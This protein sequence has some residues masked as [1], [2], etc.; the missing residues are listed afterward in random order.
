MQFRIERSRVKDF[1]L[2]NNMKKKITFFYKR[3]IL[4]GTETLILRMSKWLKQN[5]YEVEV[6]CNEIVEEL[7]RSFENDGIKIIIIKNFTIKEYLSQ[8]SIYNFDI[9]F[10]V[11]FSF[12][13]YFFSEYMKM[14]LKNKKIKNI[15]YVLLP[16][17]TLRGRTTKITIK[18]KVVKHIY[19]KII[20]KMYDSNSIFFMDEVCIESCSK[21]YNLNMDRSYDEIIRLPMFINDIKLKNTRKSP[22]LNILAIAR[23]DFP[24]KGY[25]FGLIDVINELKK[26]NVYLTIIGDG[27]GMEEIRKKIK[28]LG[29]GDVI[30]LA[31]NVPYNDLRDYFDR[32][33]LYVGMGTTLLDASNF[34]VPAISVYTHTYEFLT[35]GF[36]YEYPHLLGGN[37]DNLEYPREKG[38]NIVKKVMGMSS[39]EYLEI[40]RKSYDS[41]KNMYDINKIMPKMLKICFFSDNLLFSSYYL[42]IVSLVSVISNILKRKKNSN[43]V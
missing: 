18:K 31:G 15:F 21:Y 29:A 20:K 10:I 5:E 38:I 27:Q 28:S 3:L 26:K 12:Q 17:H 16:T 13:D 35:T 2:I 32:A 19:K 39:S 30:R 1:I 8:T 25:L 40:C 34:T 43:N 6:V 9:Q 36:F 22:L 33:D 37:E 24:F 7:K 4:G 14:R 42:K 11:T 41:L 23:F